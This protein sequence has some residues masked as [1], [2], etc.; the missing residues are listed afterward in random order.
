MHLISVFRADMFTGISVALS[1]LTLVITYIA[2]QWNDRSLVYVQSP[3]DNQYYRVIPKLDQKQASIMLSVIRSKIHLMYK[4]LLTHKQNYPQFVPYIN[5]FCQKYPQFVWIENKPNNRY[6]SYTLNK[7]EQIVICLRSANNQTLHHL[8]VVMYVV[9]HE[10]AHVA[11]PEKNHTPLFVQI[12][13]FFIK[14]A[15]MLNIYQ[16]HR[17]DLSPVLY[18]GLTINENLF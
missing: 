14:I 4:H 7:G 3:L 9:L 13:V 2:L 10:L 8:N 17:Y 15:I 16:H 18:C 6:V 1:V 12:F 5:Q 11:C